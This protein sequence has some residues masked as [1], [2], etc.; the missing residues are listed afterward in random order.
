MPGPPFKVDYTAIG[1]VLGT[2]GWD[3]TVRERICSHFQ[4]PPLEVEPRHH[5]LFDSFERGYM[6]FEQ[7][8]RRVF[9]ASPRNFTVED[10]RAY[11]YSASIPW[12][13]NIIFF[14]TLKV[15]NSV[16]LA[17]ISNEGEGL[18]QHRVD[19]FGLRQLADFLV[20]SHFVHF[21]KPDPEIW[22]LALDLAQ[23]R[24]EE[25]LYIDDRQL[26]VST[27]AELG[28]TAF[29]YESLQQTRAQ[30]QILG[31]TIE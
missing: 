20:I 6:T 30:L 16:K 27:A 17:L 12:H 18:T 3:G 2:N 29:R 5:L 1:G 9:L 11:A 26:F 13:E 22:R 21:R 4:V 28:F 8:L 10:L 14:G 31:F 23:V 7:Y 19:K 24:S 25:C 15:E